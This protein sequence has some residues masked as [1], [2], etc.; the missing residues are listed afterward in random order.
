MAASK[1]PGPCPR[2]KAA[3]LVAVVRVRAD[4]DHHL[5]AGD[6]GRDQR[7]PAAA[8][9]LARPRGLERAASPGCT[10]VLGQV[11]LVHLEGVRERAVGNRGRGSMHRGAARSESAALAA[12]AFLR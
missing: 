11:R 2:V 1:R 9:L 4:P 10:P 12:G 3:A 8:A 6:E 5:G 7:A